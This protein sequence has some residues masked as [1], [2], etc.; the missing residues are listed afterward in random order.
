MR[1]WTRYLAMRD[2]ATALLGL[3]VT[4][5]VHADCYTLAVS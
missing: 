4:A 1:A 3:P 5:A 2:A